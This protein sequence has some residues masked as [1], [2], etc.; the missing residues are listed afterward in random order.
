MKAKHKKDAQNKILRKKP[1]ENVFVITTVIS[2]NTLATWCEE[3]TSGS[4]ESLMLEKTEGRRRGGRQRMRWLDGITDSMDMS[5]SKLQGM[6][7]DRE[8]WCAAVRG[9]TK[10]QTWLS[11]WETTTKESY[12]FSLHLCSR[13]WLSTT[14][15]SLFLFLILFFFQMASSLF[16]AS[17]VGKN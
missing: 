16:L 11:T 10:S 7:S 6:V 15:Y 9:V 5:L 12:K 17:I 1:H 13:H 4:E 2:A 8:A 14:Y 3:Q